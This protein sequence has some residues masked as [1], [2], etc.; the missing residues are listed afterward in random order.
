MRFPYFNITF[1]TSEFELGKVQNSIF[2]GRLQ[3]RVENKGHK[4]WQNTSLETQLII[5]LIG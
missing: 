3:E 4:E 1:P 2:K 5:R